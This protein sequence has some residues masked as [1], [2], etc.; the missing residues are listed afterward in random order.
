MQ[1]VTGMVLGGTNDF[2]VDTGAITGSNA[3]GSTVKNAQDIVPESGDFSTAEMPTPGST[4][5]I[6][7]TGD[8]GKSFTFNVK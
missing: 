5:Q 3:G 6:T 8:D 7:Y 2:T 1:K 4:T